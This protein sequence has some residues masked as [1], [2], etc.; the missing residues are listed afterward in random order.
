MKAKSSI[1]VFS[2][3]TA[4]G[5]SGS[6]VHEFGPQIAGDLTV[7]KVHGFCPLPVCLC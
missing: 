3:I 5:L 1:A 7:T 4:E 6:V 2:L